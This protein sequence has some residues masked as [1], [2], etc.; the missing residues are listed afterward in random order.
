[1]RALDVINNCILYERDL[2]KEIEFIVELLQTTI[3]GLA[4]RH[5]L[6]RAKIRSIQSRF[7]LLPQLRPRRNDRISGDDRKTSRAQ[8]ENIT[9]QLDRKSLLRF[10][11]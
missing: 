7:R 11:F 1:M 8:E 6:W 10:Q 5:F 4:S 9:F 3:I 2:R